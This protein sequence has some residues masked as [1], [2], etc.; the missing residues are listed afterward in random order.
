MKFLI[1]DHYYPRFLAQFARLNRELPSLSY[2][3]H[4]HKLYATQ[5]GTADFYSH[6]LRVLGHEA[7]DVVVNYDLLQEQWAKEHNLANSTFL[8]RILNY[9]WG[10]IPPLAALKAS[11]RQLAILKA[12]IRSS[13]PDVLYVQIPTYLPT[14]YLREIKQYVKLIVGQIAS[15]IPPFHYFR[16]FDLMITS[17]PHFVEKFKQMGLKA[18]YL[19]L[20]FDPR[21][22]KKP[23]PNRIY[24]L[25]FV[26]SF[27]GVHG[28]WLSTLSQVAKIAKLR[29]WGYPDPKLPEYQGEAWGRDMYSILQKS[30]ITLN[31]HSLVAGEYANNMRLFEAT[32]CGAMLLTDAKTNIADFFVPGKEV[33]VYHSQA[34]LLRQVVYY[35]QHQEE[36]ARIGKSGQRRTLRDHTYAIRMRQLIKIIERNL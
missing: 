4:L 14:S 33:A 23:S 5:F 17:L 1:V 15:P 10:V 31:R 26:G 32:G 36:C 11:P 19:P 21:I 29:I 28:S 2:N 25:T 18:E 13:R 6:A 30:Q 20:C 8:E 22:L 9:I 16:G 35:L 12:Q 3:K 7:H 34:D 27:F 24:P